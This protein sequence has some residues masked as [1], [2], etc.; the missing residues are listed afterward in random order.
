[1]FGIRIIVPFSHKWEKGL[2]MRVTI[3]IYGLYSPHPVSLSHS[4]LMGEGKKLFK[5]DKHI[6]IFILRYSS[7][8]EKWI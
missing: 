4:F 8:S 6:M 5:L 7:Q 1:M 3:S 2:G